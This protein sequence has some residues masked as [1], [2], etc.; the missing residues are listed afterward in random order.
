MNKKFAVNVKQF[1]RRYSIT[2]EEAHKL[3]QPELF[4]LGYS[5]FSN[6]KSLQYED[7]EVI[8]AERDG[9]LSYSDE[10]YY[11]Q[12]GHLIFPLAKLNVA[13]NVSLIIPKTKSLSGEYTKEE[14]E[15]ILK[16]WDNA[17]VD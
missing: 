4:K 3:I 11:D 17:Q 16:G 6:G 2:L 12:E 15:T 5:W 13:L 7:K 10:L 14:I 9:D 1:A 8:Y